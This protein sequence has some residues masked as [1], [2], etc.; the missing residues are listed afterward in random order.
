[1]GAYG[2]FCLPECQYEVLL[3]LLLIVYQHPVYQDP[4][5][6]VDYENWVLCKPALFEQVCK[7]FPDT[8]VASS[9]VDL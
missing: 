4:F 5:S 6:V 9:T 8:Y 3:Q 2:Y 7:A 1:M